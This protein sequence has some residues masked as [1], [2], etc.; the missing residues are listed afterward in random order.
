MRSLVLL[1]CTVLLM[2][3]SASSQTT[4][5][6][7]IREKTPT[8]V[9]LVNA[10][11]VVSPGDVIPGAIII[12][13]G[14][15]QKVVS[16]DFS[17]VVPTGA[18][19][20]DFTGMTIYP[21]FIDPYTD[22]GLP[23]AKKSDRPESRRPQYETERVGGSAWNEAIHADQ[24][25]SDH[26]Q[27]DSNAAREF[28]N[29][30]ITVVQTARLDGIWRGRSS[31]VSLDSD[32][33]N[34]LI[35]RPYSHHFASFD[36]GSSRQE[37]PSSLMG[38]I[39]LIRQSLLDAEW[40]TAARRAFQ[41]NPAQKLPEFNSDL[42][43]LADARDETIIFE[44]ADEL[45]FLRAGN[46]AE[47]FKCS[48]VHLGSNRE[49]ARI[50]QITAI[51]PSII[52]P[53]N[54]PD[55][56]QVK[57]PE[58]ELDV[59]L[60]ELRHWETAPSNPAI[61]TQQNIPFAFTTHG[62][63]KKSD[64]LKNIC[65]AVNR[66]LDK[67]TALAALTTIP[68]GFCGI[69]DL[70]GSIK[71]GN[72]ANFVVCDGDL[73]DDSTHVDEVWIR[74]KRYKLEPFPGE[75]IRGTYSLIFDDLRAQLSITGKRSQPSGKFIIAA[76]SIRMTNLDV[77]EDNLHFI[78]ELDSGAIEGMT[79]FSGR[80]TG[81]TLAGYAVLPDGKQ[82]EWT[83]TLTQPFV[84]DTDSEESKPET[85]DSLL[86]NRT[87]P[88]KAFG[89]K[90]LP[91]P[92]DVLIKNAAV[93][94]S[95]PEG[96][97][98]NHDILIQNGRFEKIGSNLAAP[99]GIVIIDATGK[100]VTPG[101]IDEHSHIAI[102]GN[103]NEGTH[104][105]TSEVRI[106]DIIDSDDIEIYR[107]LAGGATTSH[108]LHGSANPIGGQIVVVKFRWGSSAQD[109]ILEGTPATI[110]F[111]LGENVKQSNWGEQYTVRY[112]QTRMGVEAIIRDAFQ[113][114]REYE[115]KWQEYEQLDKKTRDRT[116]PPRR[117][118]QLEALVDILNSEMFVHCH[119][120]HQSEMLMLM[121]LA[122]DFGFRITTFEHALEAYKIADELARYGTMAAVFSDWWAYK[123]EVYDA[124]P[125]CAAL[126]TERGVLTSI[127]SDS[128][129]LA[130]RLNQ[131]AAKTV[132]YGDVSQEDALK[133][134]T[135]NPA[136]QLKVQDRIGS[137]KAGK[138]ADFVIWNN[139][140]LSVYAVPEQTW[141]EGKKY[142]D[143]ERD[144]EL[145]RLL[146]QEKQALIQKV[147]ATGSS[148]KDDK[149]KGRHSPNGESA[150]GKS[151]DYQS[152]EQRSHR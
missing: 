141:I 97:L 62:L 3:I 43:A 48:F 53:V 55:A 18:R 93:W 94:T 113:A 112:P 140:P 59:T 22:Y 86:A 77:D 39:A 17:P 44:T 20:I 129:E 148:G 119:A 120:Y 32:L 81:D 5:E 76:D 102:S 152:S 73:F 132:M 91:K 98:E 122:D 74:G 151:Q 6:L 147:L 99:E 65:E 1:C 114:A 41:L 56:P 106:E 108:L 11:V 103:V 121:Q 67:E 109:M 133:M 96:I 105:V 52:L 146:Q 46:I 29:Q 26:F 14:I 110:K 101:I 12:R 100:H 19:I 126:L 80:K 144:K 130:R 111:A 58:D 45:S 34:H 75:D 8:T 10:K 128:R 79:R 35:I 143:I 84:P 28:I 61:L 64:Y 87:F 60:A 70:C 2:A 27:P 123:F 33:P 63:K 78:V 116:V 23:E 49:Y 51:N 124:I 83:A 104:A 40:Y 135:I 107:Q 37:Y 85:A 138:D 150:Q 72:M 36:K 125:Y 66:G 24:N 13:N 82:V 25:W 57:T 134:V 89:F 95:E 9:A 71:E 30:G 69:Q 142:F 47:E 16:D 15:I 38:A 118:L 139:N 137:I 131:E 42:M 92:Q 50:E 149:N 117:D 88:N 21:G 136:I 4:P 54:Y 127:K 31:V 90:E 7:G 68:A 145:R 115:Q